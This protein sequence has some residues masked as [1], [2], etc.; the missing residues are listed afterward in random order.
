MGDPFQVFLIYITTIFYHADNSAYL[1]ILNFLLS[2]VNINM[3]ETFI[4]S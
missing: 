4:A 3:K 1:G 2:P